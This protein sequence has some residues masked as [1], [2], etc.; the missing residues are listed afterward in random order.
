MRRFIATLGLVTALAAGT[1][2]GLLMAGAEEE[3]Q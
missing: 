1:G 3:A 2:T